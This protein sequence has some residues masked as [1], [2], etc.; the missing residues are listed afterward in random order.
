MKTSYETAPMD[1]RHD[2][3]DASAPQR[4]HYAAAQT[5]LTEHF[6]NGWKTPQL[7]ALARL[8]SEA[9]K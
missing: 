9:A 3:K 1:Q 2:A 7:D 6:G 8:L 4:S 5:Y